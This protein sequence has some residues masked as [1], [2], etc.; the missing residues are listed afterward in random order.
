MQ[1]FV[2]FICLT[3]LALS[4]FP[5]EDRCIWWNAVSLIIS[6]ISYTTRTHSFH[7]TLLLEELQEHEE[8]EQEEEEEEDRWSPREEY[9]SAGYS[10]GVKKK[11]LGPSIDQEKL[12]SLCMYLSICLVV[13]FLRKLKLNL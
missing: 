11:P 9:R 10:Y 8:E 6:L 5:T 7:I 13:D 3:L 2:T 4:Y 12:P 1:Y